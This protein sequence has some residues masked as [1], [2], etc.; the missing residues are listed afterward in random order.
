MYITYTMDQLFLPM[1]LEEDI[2]AH[3]LVRIVNEAVNQLD[4]KIFAI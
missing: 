2:P 3:H 1:D 4:D